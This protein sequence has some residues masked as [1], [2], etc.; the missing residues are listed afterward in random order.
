MMLIFII[1]IDP[2][3]AFDCVWIRRKG[4]WEGI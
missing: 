1:L 4:M 3:I 2:L